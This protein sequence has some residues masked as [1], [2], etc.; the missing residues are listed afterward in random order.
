MFSLYRRI[1]V[2]GQIPERNHDFTIYSLPLER[3]ICLSSFQTHL[4]NS[5][6]GRDMLIKI[7]LNINAIPEDTHTKLCLIVLPFC[8][9]FRMCILKSMS[10]ASSLQN[11]PHYFER[12]QLLR[13][14]VCCSTQL[15]QNWSNPSFP[16]RRHQEDNDDISYFYIFKC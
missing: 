6:G 7:I 1:T 10:V 9:C 2:Q 3:D 4:K 16:W 11:T 8:I 14:F 12:T 15:K 5:L 13:V